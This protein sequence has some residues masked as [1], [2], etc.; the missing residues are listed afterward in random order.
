MGEGVAGSSTTRRRSALV[1]RPTTNGTG[2]SFT[3]ARLLGTGQRPRCSTPIRL[4]CRR[5]LGVISVLADHPD[6]DA[7]DGHAVGG[8]VHGLHGGVGRLQ[9]HPGSLAVE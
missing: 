9:A 6:H 2:S 8:V 5:G 7:L 3:I 4:R 1:M